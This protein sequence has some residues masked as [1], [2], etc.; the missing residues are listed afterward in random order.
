MDLGNEIYSPDNIKFIKRA[1]YRRIWNPQFLR[2]KVLRHL[3]S[4]FP[5]RP[6]VAKEMDYFKDEL[7]VP[8]HHQLYVS[9]ENYMVVGESAS[10]AK[11]TRNCYE[12]MKDACI[13][14]PEGFELSEKT[15][16]Q[17]EL[18]ERSLMSSLVNKLNFL[19][20]GE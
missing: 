3:F 9:E 17:G 18:K 12:S 10:R 4:S 6:F 19:F 8:A 15:I 16:I 2:A 5:D 20:G 7:Q 14:I 11:I 13:E 1:N